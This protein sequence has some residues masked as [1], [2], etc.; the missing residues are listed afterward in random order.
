MDSIS[1]LGHIISVSQ[2]WS[3]L[4]KSLRR[5]LRVW[6]NSMMSSIK[7]TRTDTDQY[8]N[9]HIYQV[10]I[11]SIFLKWFIYDAVFSDIIYDHSNSRSLSPPSSFSNLF[12]IK[13]NR[14]KSVLLCN[15]THL[16]PGLSPLKFNIALLLSTSIKLKKPQT[17][18]PPN[19][20]TPRIKYQKFLKLWVTPY[21]QFYIIRYNPVLQ[22]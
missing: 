5:S 15:N 17:A 16:T 10:K 3:C 9:Y 12:R 2:H 6:K 18:S 19:P 14:P 7:S 11:F 20:H 8:V 4:N 13:S 22:I 1:F 21:F